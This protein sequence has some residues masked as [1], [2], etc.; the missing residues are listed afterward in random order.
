MQKWEYVTIYCD[1]GTDWDAEFNALGEEG[2]EMV[3]A[4]GKNFIFKRSLD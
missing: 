2:W 3:A 1:Y 4:S